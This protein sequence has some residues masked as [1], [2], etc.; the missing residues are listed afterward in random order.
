M[1][2]RRRGCEI[3]IDNV[4]LFCEFSLNFMENRMLTHLRQTFQVNLE[5]E[6]CGKTWLYTLFV[7]ET[8]FH[9]QLFV[10][11]INAYT[12]V[13]KHAL[14][15]TPYIICQ[16]AAAQSEMQDHDSAINSFQVVRRMDPYRID[17]M[18]LFSNSLYIQVF[19]KK[20][21]TIRDRKSQ[22]FRIL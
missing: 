5:K 15:S 14:G 9:L 19:I 2:A 1:C 20:F 12:E 6:E 18:H 21:D 16:I 8:M 11:S 22:K 7:A 17:Q 3:K 4:R 10:C 13:S